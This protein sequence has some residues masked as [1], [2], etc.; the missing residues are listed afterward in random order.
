MDA[1][2][3]PL[4]K[5][6]HMHMDLVGLWPQTVEGHTHLLTVVDRTM[7]WAEAV[8]LQSTTAQVVADSFV[9]NWVARFGV[10]AT[11]TTNQGNPV[12]LLHVA[13]HVQSSGQQANADYC[14]P[15]SVKRD[16]GEVSLAVE[17]SATCKV[18]RS[19]LAGPLA[20]G[21][22][23]AMCS[24]QGGSWSV[25]SGGHLWPFAGAAQ[26]AATASAC[27]TGCSN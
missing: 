15:P 4:H 11:I 12:H 21:A 14:L 13:M 20:L 9:V 8:Q 1:I 3:V 27:T 18:Q 16:G 5:F 6:S 26:P 2:P 24:S 23:G 22:F 17:G 10:P 7:R 19:G 25:G